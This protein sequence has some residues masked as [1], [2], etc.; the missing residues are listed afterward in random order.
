MFLTA[1]LLWDGLL[2][3]P[4]RPDGSG[5]CS[6]KFPSRCLTFAPVAESIASGFPGF[7]RAVAEGSYLG[8]S[9]A[10]AAAVGERRDGR[11]E[12]PEEDQVHPP[13]AAP[14][15]GNLPWDARRIPTKPANLQ[16]SAGPRTGGWDGGLAFAR[17]VGGG[18]VPGS[19]TSGTAKIPS[20]CDRYV[21]GT[22]RGGNAPVGRRPRGVRTMRRQNASGGSE[23]PARASPR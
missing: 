8:K 13:Q 10:P 5:T 2:P 21:V 22:P 17:G 15:S 4:S 20:A 18:I 9:I 6:S 7:L 1:L 19:G 23:V 14:G 3:S 11:G 12:V 16:A